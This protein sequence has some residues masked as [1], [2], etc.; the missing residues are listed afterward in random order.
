[1]FSPEKIWES[2]KSEGIGYVEW[3]RRFNLKFV[4]AAVP[5]RNPLDYKISSH[6]YKRESLADREFRNKYLF[7]LLSLY[8]CR[9]A[10]C[11]SQENGFH[12]DHHWI[13]KSY[14]GDFLMTMKTGQ[15]VCNAVPLCSTCNLR[16]SDS[17]TFTSPSD[18]K[19]AH[20]NNI[21]T[22]K[23]AGLPPVPE[24]GEKYK[25]TEQDLP[26]V[27]R[28]CGSLYGSMKREEKI[29]GITGLLKYL[30]SVVGVFE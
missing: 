26:W 4:S 10:V 13:P 12:L 28:R 8:E 16:K 24:S 19:I 6:S 21:F 30:N 20:L 3:I 29:G 11:G 15:L 18:S 25:I 5:T 2:A 9:C 7:Q 23:I 14:G 27:Y 22:A 17:I 1:M